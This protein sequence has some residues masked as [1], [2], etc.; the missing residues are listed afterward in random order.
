MKRLSALVIGA[1]LLSLTLL[2]GATRVTG[3]KDLPLPA[4]GY[5]YRVENPRPDEYLIVLRNDLDPSEK[6]GTAYELAN[7]F[8]G[9]VLLVP[10][11]EGLNAFSI[12]MKEED[13]L[14]LSQ[15]SRVQ[16]VEEIPEG[17]F[18]TEPVIPE[19]VEGTVATEESP[20]A[21]GEEQIFLPGDGGFGGD[22]LNGKPPEASSPDPEY[23]VSNLISPLPPPDGIL[24]KAANPRYFKY[25][26]QTVALLGMS[27]SYLPHIARSRPRNNG[28]DP[29]KENCTRDLV[30]NP[31]ILKY[32][33][34]IA[35]LKQ[36]NLNHMQIWVG[37]NHSVGKLPMEVGTGT[38]GSKPYA[39]EQPF[40]WNGSQW[41]LNVW[42]PTSQ[43]DPNS[44][45]TY[46]RSVVQYAQDKGIIVAIVLF[47]PWSGW[48]KKPNGTD[49]DVPQYSP[50][51]GPNNT[52]GL[53]FSDPKFFVQGDKANATP[54]STEI[55][56]QFIPGTQIENPNWKLRK[57][58]VGLMKRTA[59]ELTNLKNFYWVLA[60]EPDMHGK[61]TGTPLITWHKYMAL[62]LWDY[63][64]RF[65]GKR[66]HLIAANL[67]SNDPTTTEPNPAVDDDA[68]TQLQKFDKIDILTG[69]YV[70]LKSP[71]GDLTEA[72][73]YSALKLLNV[74]NTYKPNGTWDL[75][76]TKMFGFT[77][78][79][80][81]G[82][83]K[84]NPDA[85]TNPANPHTDDSARV[86]AWEFFMNGGGLFDHLAYRWANP[87]P[88][89][90]GDNRLVPKAVLTYYS[91][92]SKFMNPVNLTNMRR[93]TAN[94]NQNW[95]TD[96]PTYD[97]P[98]TNSQL[99]SYHNAFWGAISNG[100]DQFFFYMHRS[101][102]ANLGADRY[103]VFID[104]PRP[105]K[106]MSFRPGIAGC[107]KAEWFYPD[108][109]KIGN[110]PTAVSNNGD[111]LPIFTQQV[112]SLTA[113]G[114][115]TLTCPTYK[116]DVILR[117]TKKATCS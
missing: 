45:F 111:L 28:F 71:K 8:N 12:S 37:L 33:N 21:P 81:T 76:N 43:A 95:I 60:N 40:K 77:E 19:E 63:E 36:N 96:P 5:I 2:P 18:A 30:G 29:V 25:G 80:P 79:Q 84:D 117:I 16:F 93:L 66:H 38:N 101:A 3:Q 105:G 48:G 13:A 51:Y 87:P 97:A 67:A 90:T 70:K 9:V 32:Q 73:R 108:G 102:Y 1:L 10:Y 69:H 100:T 47:D 112:P 27:G 58:Q 61:A 49:S 85:P 98:G 17:D 104:N 53:S 52:D 99:P 115:Y 56:N 92:L 6:E 78:G 59:D 107:Y 109:K 106:S 35:T 26:G 50:W 14:A 42:D 72:N 55:D 34:C 74:Y 31:A 88:T 83:D 7:T 114:S 44:Y 41:N 11:R 89:A 20:G 39:H 113:T 65:L 86:E 64:E 110:G 91:Y 68:I 22:E 15:D 62:Q 4:K 94:Q 54:T 57:I 82:T 46:L 23:P 75:Y 24:S 116:Q 103:K